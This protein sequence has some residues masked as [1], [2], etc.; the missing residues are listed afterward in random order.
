[1]WSIRENVGDVCPNTSI[2]R[3]KQLS[4]RIPGRRSMGLSPAV[5]SLPPSDPTAGSRLLQCVTSTHAGVTHS[6]TL[7][8]LWFAKRFSA[9][10]IFRKAIC[11][12]FPWH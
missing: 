12:V 7:P 4:W 5:P 1:M 3:L 6:R 8:E 9:W 2:E 11:V 10:K